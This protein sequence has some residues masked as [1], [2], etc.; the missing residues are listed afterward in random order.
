MSATQTQRVVKST[1]PL[2][3]IIYATMFL[4]GLTDNVKG[5]SYPLI[6]TDFG[7]AYDSQGG[8]V[9]LAWLGYV[10][11]CLAASLFL[12]RF[13]VK[14]AM[15]A[16]YVLV[17]GGAVATLF[18]PSFWFV[19]LTLLV[20][21]AGFGFYEV[22]TNALGTVIFTRRAALMMNLMHFFY[23]VGA[24][25]GPKAAGFLTSS[26]NLSWRQVYI[27]VIIPTGAV[28]L[29]TLL[30]RFQ[31]RGLSSSGTHPEERINFI[32]ALKNPLVWTFCL[33]V[34]LMEVIE[35]GPA[36]WGGL[37]LQDVFGLDVRVAG[38]SFV[39]LFFILFTISRLVLGPVIEKLGYLRSLAIA[40]GATILLLLA[41]FSLGAA[42]IWV[43]PVT[44]FFIGM[45]WPTSMAVGMQVFRENAP[46]VTS[47]IITVAGAI[48]GLLQLAIG[49]TSQVAG[50]A[51]GYR[52]TLVYAVILLGLLGLLASQSRRWTA[53]R[54][55]GAADQPGV[56]PGA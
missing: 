7:Q 10:V 46:A 21:N 3:L 8:L 52:S 31:D 27:A 48:N 26:L 55:A 9:S 53:A 16:G 13:G 17:A 36:N 34:G 43:L 35:M 1:L 23:G 56:M 54:D 32:T 20:I 22:G 12:H 25:L 50:P 11:F 24:I 14:K 51:W 15:L 41:G 18:A 6:K 19:G 4:F 47:V 40:T 42:G 5:V 49:L 28:F 38:A 33:V 29:Y 45:L 30:T 39:S 37:Y 44:G 2:I